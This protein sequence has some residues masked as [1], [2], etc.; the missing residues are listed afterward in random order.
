MHRPKI[1]VNENLRNDKKADTD[2]EQ[3]TNAKPFYAAQRMPVT[4][5]NFERQKK[6]SQA[7]RT[8][9]PVLLLKANAASS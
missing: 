3:F 1:S 9:A 5:V 2:N 7:G 8:S 6:F 4:K